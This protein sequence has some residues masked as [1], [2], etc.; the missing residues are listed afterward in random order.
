MAH[1]I[2]IAA[3]FK[4]LL[5]RTLAVL[6]LFTV[7]CAGKALVE[8]PSVRVHFAPIVNGFRCPARVAFT[9]M[10]HQPILSALE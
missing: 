9:V 1:L 7:A 2:S 3:I 10:L 5:V 6:K 4:K 8:L